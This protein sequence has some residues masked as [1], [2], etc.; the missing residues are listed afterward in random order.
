MVWV[1][2]FGWCCAFSMCIQ[3]CSHI[4]ANICWMKLLLQAAFNSD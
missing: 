2:M 1:G 4:A 3:S